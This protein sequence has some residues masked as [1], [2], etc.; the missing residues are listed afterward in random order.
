MG[1]YREMLAGK[2]RRA[3]SGTIRKLSRRQ[4]EEDELDS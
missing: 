3:R 2:D 4:V 1:G